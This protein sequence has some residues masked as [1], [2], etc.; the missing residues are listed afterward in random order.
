M[1]NPLLN[2]QFDNLKSPLILFN[3]FQKDV[4]DQEVKI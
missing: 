3:E 2:Y 4:D 1:T